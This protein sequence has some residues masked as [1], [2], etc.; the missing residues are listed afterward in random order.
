MVAAVIL[1]VRKLRVESLLR[2][3][4]HYKTSWCLNNYLVSFDVSKSGVLRMMWRKAQGRTI[5]LCTVSVASKKEIEE[6]I[7]GVAKC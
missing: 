4:A 2:C 5:K 6:H 3:F 1:K 7:A